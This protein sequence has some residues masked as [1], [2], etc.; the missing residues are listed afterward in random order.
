MGIRTSRQVEYT[1]N[2]HNDDR[3]TFVTVEGKIYE[4]IQVAPSLSEFMATWPKDKANPKVRTLT[5]IPIR[6]K[7]EQQK[8]NEDADFIS[9]L[10]SRSNG[11]NPE[12]V[13]SVKKAI[14][15]GADIPKEVQRL[16]DLKEK[17]KDEAE[18]RR[19]RKQLRKLDYKRYINQEEK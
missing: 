13:T 12:K 19:I 15:L 1:T 17:T 3:E 5:P 16:L 8:C 10:A 6:S 18:L 11:S 9:Q 2:F 7:A 14:S 4:L